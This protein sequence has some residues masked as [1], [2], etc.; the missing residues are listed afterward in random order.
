MAH[1]DSCT[2]IRKA[3]RHGQEGRD[4]PVHRLYFAVAS[5]SISSARMSMVPAEQSYQQQIRR[6][7]ATFAFDAASTEMAGPTRT[8]FHSSH[9]PSSFSNIAVEIM[10]SRM[11][12]VAKQEEFC[13]G[14]RQGN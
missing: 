9:L 11:A 7:A 8:G 10:R 12:I 1:R 6:S 2:L 4:Y 13:C 14:P 3:R 5:N